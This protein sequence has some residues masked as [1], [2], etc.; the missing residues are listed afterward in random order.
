MSRTTHTP[1]VDTG[2]LG[3]QVYD[4]P[5]SAGSQSVLQ[6]PLAQNNKRRATFKY[7]LQEV[8]DIQTHNQFKC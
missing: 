6:E 3:F 8:P 2:G 5:K 1:K 4:L 7:T